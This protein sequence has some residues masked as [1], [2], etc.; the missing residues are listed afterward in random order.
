MEQE[1][2]TLSAEVS[3]IVLRG[4]Q[5]RCKKVEDKALKN[6]MLFLSDMHNEK[7]TIVMNG[8]VIKNKYGVQQYYVNHLFS[9][10]ILKETGRRKGFVYAFNW[11]PSEELAKSVFDYHIG[12]NQY[13]QYPESNIDSEAHK[14]TINPKPKRRRRKKSLWRRIIKAFEEF[15]K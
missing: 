13:G 4:R 8:V 1:T 2:Q 5:S 11:Q 14:A 12:L 3:A 6:M 15:V 9:M 7:K 10:G